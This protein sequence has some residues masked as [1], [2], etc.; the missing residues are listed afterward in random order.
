MVK[1]EFINGDKESYELKDIY[2]HFRYDFDEQSY[3]FQT[4]EGFLIVPREFIKS[5]LIVGE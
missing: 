3:Q 1:I 4:M 5:I 2:P